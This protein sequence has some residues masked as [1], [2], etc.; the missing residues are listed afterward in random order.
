[1]RLADTISAGVCNV[2]LCASL[3]HSG[4]IYY[5][6]SDRLYVYVLDGS[7]SMD[8]PDSQVSIDFTGDSLI[9]VKK[10][11]TE[12]KVLAN[13]QS[14]CAFWVGFMKKKGNDFTVEKLSSGT[15][16]LTVSNEVRQSIF[17]LSGVATVNGKNIDE[18]CF[19]FL[20]KGGTSEIFLQDGTV[21]FIIT[22]QQ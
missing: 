9:D 22:E 18:Q 17:V 5:E 1:M 16:S 13:I 15:S 3:K 21:A 19:A 6:C 10:F 8:Y 12:T 14:H 20:Q 11:A 2:C 7:G 4:H